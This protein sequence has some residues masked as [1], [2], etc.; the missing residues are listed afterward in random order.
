MQSEILICVY[1]GNLWCNPFFSGDLILRKQLISG[2]SVNR[3]EV[4][5]KAEKMNHKDHKAFTQSPQTAKI[6]SIYF[7]S[8]V[9]A[10]CTLWLKMS[11]N[12]TSSFNHF[13]LF[14]Q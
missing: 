5:L 6:Q 4:V 14:R 10:L 9:P 8:L 7:V 12:T 2:K 3:K 13:L 11:F 1:P